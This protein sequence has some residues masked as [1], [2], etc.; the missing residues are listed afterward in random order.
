MIRNRR[1]SRWSALSP[2]ATSFWLAVL[3]LLIVGCGGVGDGSA[4]SDSPL[5]T[6]VTLG[7]VAGETADARVLARSLRGTPFPTF[8]PPPTPW[9][10][11]SAS[12]PTG[13]AEPPGTVLPPLVQPA[14]VAPLHPGTADRLPLRFTCVS[15]FR[16]FL[17]ATRSSE[18]VHNFPGAVADFRV[19]RSDC[20]SPK[21]EMVYSPF[22]L[23]SGPGTVGGVLV[24]RPLRTGKAYNHNLRLGPSA[25]DSTGNLL[26]HFRR[27][28]GQSS[29]GCWYYS[30]AAGRWF[31]ETLA[32]AGSSAGPT[33]RPTVA[34]PSGVLL[35]GS[36]SPI[37][38]T[39]VDEY[40]S[41]LVSLASP[42]AAVHMAEVLLEVQTGI[43]SCSLEWRPELSAVPLAG[44]CPQVPTGSAEE[45]DRLVLHWTAPPGDRS[46]CW[47]YHV[48]SGVWEVR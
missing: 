46:S 42:V 17:V 15:D 47:I 33:P 44:H 14:V 48:P 7:G 39:C 27:L 8:T 16:D 34:A 36:L 31:T 41:R 38:R 20:V 24:A 4:P 11:L 32:V 25:V 22:P 18:L 26:L 5:P 40:R 43:A 29:A 45:P 37:H 30:A 12:L 6:R 9:P 2:V 1:C 10:V 13:A 28:P 35:H 23:C 21:F 19:L 3:V